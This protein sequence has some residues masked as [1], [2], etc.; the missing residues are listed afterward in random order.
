MLADFNVSKSLTAVIIG[1]KK[2][3]LPL[4]GKNWALKTRGKGY[5]YI[6]SNTKKYSAAYSLGIKSCRIV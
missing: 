1:S 2:S 6:V 4:K 3:I 5:V